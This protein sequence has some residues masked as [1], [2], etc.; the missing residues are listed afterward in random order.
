[1]AAI[2]DSGNLSNLLK[3]QYEG[4]IREQINLEAMIYNLFQEGPHEWSGANVIIPL[5]TAGV[6]AA[7]IAYQ[8]ET[9]G[10]GPAYVDVP[11]PSSQTYL[12]FTVDAK[13]LYGS[14]AVTGQAE[15]K[16]PGSSGGSEAAFVGAMYSEMR[17]LEKDIRS[18]MNTDMFTGSGILG[19]LTDNLNSSTLRHVSGLN[20]M[21]NGQVFRVWHVPRDPSKN[22]AF[23][24]DGTVHAQ[25]SAFTISAINLGNG[26][27]TLISSSAAPDG[28]QLGALGATLLPTE[29]CALEHITSVANTNRPAGTLLEI[30]G[31]NALGFGQLDRDIYGAGTGGRDLLANTVLRGFGWKGSHGAVAGVKSA[32]T[33]LALSDMQLVVDGIE[34]LVEETVDT[35]IMHRFTRAEFRDLTQ[36]NERYLPG[37]T[38][39]K[40]GFKPG[41]LAFQDIPI[42]VSKDVP[43]G[44]IYFLVADTIN[45][46]TL[47]PGGFQ[48][49]T[50]NG[51]ILTQKRNPGTGLLTDV[52]EGFWKQYFNLVSEVPRAIGVMAG[53]SFKRA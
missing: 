7:A 42:T 13:Y 45:T 14:F 48:N 2:G 6:D 50:D 34:D 53:V 25:N 43:Y 9:A 28:P 18:T 4:P 29:I 33:A 30:S 12:Q 52:R 22:W 32:G 26:T 15:A 11:A 38:S 36:K 1:M 19:F 8:D 27:A 47:K 3:S 23:V 5:H 41:D 46:Y 31:L 35:V 40:I 51:D 24:T 17:G 10:A 44:C 49:F 37:Q 16:A 20:H 21:T 39:G